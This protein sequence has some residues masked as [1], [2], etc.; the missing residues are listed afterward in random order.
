MWLF[1]MAQDLFAWRDLQGISFSEYFMI[2]QVLSSEKA[3]IG[4]TYAMAVC[5]VY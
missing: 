2:S 5:E 1:V 3:L 4:L